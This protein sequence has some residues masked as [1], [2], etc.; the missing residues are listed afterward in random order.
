[1]TDEERCE[2]AAELREL[3][4][5]YEKVPAWDV[6]AAGEL[7]APVDDV[8]MACGLGRAVHA[9]EICGRLADLIDGAVITGGTSDGYH[10]FDELYDHRAKLFSVIVKTFADRAWKSRLHHD[11]SMYDGMFIVGIDA[12]D[13]QATYHYDIDPY[14]LMF[15][16]RE[17]PRAP[18]WDGHTPAQAIERIAGLADLIEP[19]VET[20]ELELTWGGQTNAHVRTYE[21]SRCGKSCDSVWGED[22]EFCP[23][24][25]RRVENADE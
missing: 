21:C 15:D 14:W 18:K 25:G 12:P 9:T 16:C 5:D 24:C 23:Y 4:E 7:P 2:V 17:L 1:M 22:Y 8:L 10:T 11:G 6:I 19:T 13:G 3:A 20:C